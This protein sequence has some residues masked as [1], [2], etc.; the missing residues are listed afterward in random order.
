MPNV[1]DETILSHLNWRIACKQFDPAVKVPPAQWRTIEEGFRL[2]PSSY[3]VQPWHFVIV[4]DPAV[5]AKLPEISQ[6]QR[7]PAD[8]SHVV[9]VAVRRD[10]TD[11]DLSHLVDRMAAVSGKSPDDLAGFRKIV[12]GDAVAE[13]P[14]S[15]TRYL[16]RQTYIALG[17]GLYTA[18]LLGI[19]AC[20]MEG[21]D[22]DAYDAEFKLTD[23]G[24]RTLCICCFGYRTADDPEAKKKKVRFAR[25]D[26]FTHLP[27]EK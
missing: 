17:F 16:E 19:D 2:A 24:Y 4:T 22:N 6:G 9:V 10:Y 26:V 27:P 23:Q 12:S 11:S 14:D 18:A 21:I 15:K 25:E 3:D 7:Q 1:A 20:P 13:P 5:K 8:C